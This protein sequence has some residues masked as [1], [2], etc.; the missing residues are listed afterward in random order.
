[1]RKY[2]H[3]LSPDKMRLD[4]LYIRYRSFWLDIDVILWTGL[5][6]FP[7]IKNYSPPEQLLYVGPI[8][9]F[10]Q[11]YLNWFI[12]DALVIWIAI[13]VTNLAVSSFSSTSIDWLLAIEMSLGF[14]LLCSIMG[15]VLNTNGTNWPK[16]T[17]WESARLWVSWLVA[18]V[19]VLG[20]HSYFGVMS[21]RTY[22]MILGASIL[23]L[24][25]FIFV[26]YRGRLTGGLVSRILTHGLNS[27]AVRERVLIVGSGRTAEQIAWLLDHPTY[28]GKFRVVGFIDDDLR[29]QGMRIYGSKVIGRISDVQSIV[30]EQDV[31]L[32]ILAD[33]QMAS[34]KYREFQKLASFKPARVVVAPDLF[35]SLSGV[36]E[37]APGD[38]G[39]GNLSD[40]Q[41]QHCL[42]RYA[43]QKQGLVDGA[44]AAGDAASLS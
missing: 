29:S 40:F 33:Y 9:R 4:Q 5:L 36:I 42:A 24:A 3:E 44:E 23:S 17:S 37:V 14:S 22:G 15:V 41:C 43:P 26:R 8:T 12:W 39:A 20:I 31:G 11:R 10:M 30:K 1:M 6:L 34:R 19:G 38:E 16:A 35:G 21:L 27:E 2:L 28:S 7:R 18:T 25:G 13:L 32:I